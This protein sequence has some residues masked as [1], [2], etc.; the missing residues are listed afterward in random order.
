MSIHQERLGRVSFA[1]REE[2]YA[3]PRR[4]KRT[5]KGKRESFNTL[6]FMIGMTNKFF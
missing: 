4:K 6:P 3:D 2:E 5:K 1:E